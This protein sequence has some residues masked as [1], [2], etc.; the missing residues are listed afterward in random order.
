MQK[1]SLPKNYY[2]IAIIDSSI[3]IFSMKCICELDERYTLLSLQSQESVG[4][5]QCRYTTTKLM[6]VVSVNV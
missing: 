5:L 4:I 3:I 1:L 6:V 2:D